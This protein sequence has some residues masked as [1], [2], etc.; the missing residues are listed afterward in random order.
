M[1]PRTRLLRPSQPGPPRTSVSSPGPEVLL[2]LRFPELLLQLGAGLCFAAGS[3]SFF[4]VVVDPEGI[5]ERVPDGARTRRE[6]F[7]A[8][9]FR[10]EEVRSFAEVFDMEFE[11]R[12]LTVGTVRDLG[13]LVRAP[14]GELATLG[15]D[16][17]P[18]RAC[19]TEDPKSQEITVEREGLRHVVNREDEVAHVR[20]DCHSTL[21]LLEPYES[22]ER[23]SLRD[24]STGLTDP[25][26]GPPATALSIG[27]T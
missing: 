1:D 15:L 21:I 2:L 12:V 24:R 23:A 10:L 19:L 11:R 9:A 7:H 17:R 20:N 6:T 5:S 14:E 18:D 13:E 16:H 27:D 25:R 22:D 8:N 3:D 26:S 4:A